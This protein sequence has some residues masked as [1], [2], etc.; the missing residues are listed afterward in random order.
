[1]NESESILRVLS[2]RHVSVPLLALAAMGGVA[3]AEA[4]RDPTQPANAHSVSVVPN[5]LRV[6]AILMSEGRCVA[7]ING[8]LVREGERVG[9]AVIEQILAEEVRYTRDGASH[10]V[11]LPRAS[12]TVRGEESAS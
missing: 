7:I 10:R 3:R 9:S 12:I 11:R 2:A 1:M 6:E 4:L 5:A 8:R